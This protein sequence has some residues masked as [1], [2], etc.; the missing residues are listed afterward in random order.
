MSPGD[1]RIPG[2]EDP[3]IQGHTPAPVDI[4][5]RCH[6]FYRTP[7]YAQR[8]GYRTSPRMA[9]AM[10]LYPYFVPIEQSDGPE[11]TVNGRRLVMLGSNNYLGLTTDP[12]VQEAAVRAT[13]RFGTGCTGSRFLNGT[14][15]LHE[16]LEEVLAE[17]VGMERA[18]V[19][20]T[21]YQANVGVITA[22]L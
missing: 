4:F 13:R 19:F 10:G 16:E 15:Q 12:R 1:P 17:F 18:L 7:E 21:G 8:L 11:A 3:L 5:D 6:R 22:L 20:A 2:E 14:L 9:Q